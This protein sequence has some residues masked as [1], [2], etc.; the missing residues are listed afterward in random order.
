MVTKQGTAKAYKGGTCAEKWELPIEKWERKWPLSRVQLKHTKEG[1]VQTP[2]RRDSPRR[3]H[4]PC[5]A[6]MIHGITLNYIIF[7]MNILI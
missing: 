7:I 3:L 5:T 6:V 2:E 4:F 1:H